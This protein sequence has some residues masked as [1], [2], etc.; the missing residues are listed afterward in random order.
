M[1]NDT[2]LLI[3]AAVAMA[4][5]MWLAGPLFGGTYTVSRTPEGV[6]VISNMPRPIN[7][8]ILKVHVFEEPTA[9]EYEAAA[10]ARHRDEALNRLADIREQLNK[11]TILA[12]KLLASPD[13]GKV[14]AG[15]S[16]IVVINRFK[17]AKL[18][19][20]APPKKIKP[21]KVSKPKM[22]QSKIVQKLVVILPTAT[23]PKVVKPDKG[24]KDKSGKQKA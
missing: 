24:K 2:K 10:R 20:S 9:E 17:E 6:T 14:R 1:R 7:E 22:S 5:V 13:Q 15:Q 19:S 3:Y 23:P 4:V 18:T 12:L 21:P 11:L 8:T 16:L